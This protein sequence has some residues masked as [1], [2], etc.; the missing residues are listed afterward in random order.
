MK[1]TSVTDTKTMSTVEA[2]FDKT[3]ATTLTSGAI[4]G[5]G[6]GDGVGGG[7]AGEG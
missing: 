7:W 5:M 4:V 1:S 3:V 2:V 6:R